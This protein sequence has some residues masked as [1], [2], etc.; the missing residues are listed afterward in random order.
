VV[1]ETGTGSDIA[2]VIIQGRAEFLSESP[3]RRTLINRLL[4]KYHPHLERRWGGRAMPHDRVMFRI[5]PTR[6]T[7]FGLEASAH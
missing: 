5:I 6:V 4:T 7:S 2:S 1:A 3:E